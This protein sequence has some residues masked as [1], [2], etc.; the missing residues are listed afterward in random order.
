MLWNSPASLPARRAATGTSVEANIEAMRR[1]CSRPFP[2]PAA[3]FASAL[4]TA[5]MA[6]FSTVKLPDAVLASPVGSVTVRSNVW[7]P[8]ES[9]VGSSGWVGTTP[10]ATV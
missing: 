6:P 2:A 4:P 1:A 3:T 7:V 5:T 9:P 8:S 10:T